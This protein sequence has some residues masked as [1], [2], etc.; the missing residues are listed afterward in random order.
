MVKASC[1]ELKRRWCRERVSF[2]LKIRLST[3][4]FC[5][6]PLFGVRYRRTLVLLLC[7]V[8][9]PASLAEDAAKRFAGPR[10]VKELAS[11]C[12]TAR[13]AESAVLVIASFE[14]Q[15]R[16]DPTLVEKVN[17][18]RTLWQKRAADKFVRLGKE[19]VSP[20]DKAVAASDARNLLSRAFTLIRSGDGQ[21]AA[22]LL[23]QASEADPSSV[24]ADFCLGTHY[25]LT[26]DLDA[27][28]RSFRKVLTRSPGNVGA[29]NNLAVVHLKDGKPAKAIFAWKQA[30]DRAPGNPEVL[31]NLERVIRENSQKNIHLSKSEAAKIGDLIARMYVPGK[32]GSSSSRYWMLTPP[33]V[34]DEQIPE[35]GQGRGVNG[36]WVSSGRSGTG[37]CVASG[38][39][40]TS[41]QV[42][43][44]DAYGIADLV[45]VSVP[46]SRPGTKIGAT[47]VAVSESANLVLLK[48]NS[49]PVTPVVLKRD[50][51]ALSQKVIA[52]GY[53]RDSSSRYEI[54]SVNT[55]KVKALPDAV[56]PFFLLDFPLTSS[57]CGGPLFDQFGRVIGI[58]ALVQV[59]AK[60]VPAGIP[61]NTAMTFLTPFTNI[62][63][64]EVVSADAS[65]SLQ[66]VKNASESIVL[67]DLR[68]R[69]AVPEL[70][71]TT[72]DNRSR[73]A[74]I[75]DDSC[76]SCKGSGRIACTSRQCQA[77]RIPNRYT[78][79]VVTGTGRNR[80]VSFV[81]KVRY[82][83]C[84]V[85]A[86]NV[87][88]CPNCR[89]TGR[90]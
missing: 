13:S 28:S 23:E 52:P 39:I 33:V 73:S 30:V 47:V 9:S 27:A 72:E 31:Y 63:Q 25:T 7:L 82:E 71:A 76:L 26:N 15:H 17:E 24:L 89:G 41:L 40:L 36:K 53:S 78:E 45:E 48:C 21:N 55:G 83:D 20:E 70:A 49:L 84:P 1:G 51:P 8:C 57:E 79:Q 46:Q 11:S 18:L 75:P 19:W 56:F 88:P 29:L 14:Q 86:K 3:F 22:D 6:M 66:L 87:L 12:E 67:I 65:E 80:R 32:S 2:F 38:H 50:L 37:V 4:R 42:V 43:V 90:N 16:V 81:P 77:G 10:E 34:P 60:D 54:T 5:N 44:D 58:S 64:P 68:F 59:A 62:V 85:C 69:E 74:F 35:D 61:A